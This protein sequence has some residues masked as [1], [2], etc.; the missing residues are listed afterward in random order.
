MGSVVRMPSLG[1][2]MDRGEVVAWY[3]EEGDDVAEGEVIAE[4]ESEK[5]TAEV[6]AS[7]AGVLRRVI[8]A[9]GESTAPGE[10]IA[11]VAGR[12]E[13]ISGLAASLDGPEDSSATDTGPA[14]GSTSSGATATGTSS[15]PAATPRAR[16][17]A[18]DLGVD[19]EDVAGSGPNGAVTAEDVETAAGPSSDRSRRA[20]P[21]ARRRA[22]EL[23]VDLDTVDG[24]A[25]NGGVI[26]R[27]VEAAAGVARS[28]GVRE[29]RTLTGRRGVIAD[30]LGE[31]YRE[32]VH[33]TATR[34]VDVETVFAAADA[35][36]RAL[37]VEVGVMDV[38]LRVVSD[39][40]LAHPPVNARFEDGVHRLFDGHH[41]A[42]AMDV[43]DG[44]VAPV[45]RDVGAKT[46]ADI[47]TARRRLTD[48]VVAG[49]YTNEDAAGATFTVSNL[50]P[51]GVDA[52]TPIINPP[53]VAILGIGRA[54]PVAV[55]AEDGGVA[56]RRH[57]VLSLSFDHRVLDGAD[58]AR[59]LGAIA[60]GIDDAWTAVIGR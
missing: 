6:E 13:D 35:A 43:E 9:V 15:A 39:A 33:V 8:V 22:D 56:F 52:F 23:G 24:S 2:Q 17:R 48:R 46:L 55:P 32:A 37:G 25:P 47:A 60:E 49:E 3:A 1:M 34:E 11:I 42:V 16:K 5:A 53:Q 20:T 18:R 31:S 54:R 50:G 30:R 4:I 12:D 27:D 41:I 7:Q 44:L 10:P 14:P 36:D 45:V 38:L 19:V 26:E 21:R 51:L 58:A 28:P 29:E 40:L 59:F 57:M